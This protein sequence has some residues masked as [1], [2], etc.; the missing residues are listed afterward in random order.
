MAGCHS[1]IF[2]AYPPARLLMARA[3]GSSCEQAFGLRPWRAVRRGNNY[4]LRLWNKT[5]NLVTN[6]A[7]I[8]YPPITW[9][10]IT[11]RNAK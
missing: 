8:T 3:E 2:L 4:G 6:A 10:N 7:R 5:A 1:L 11:I 9:R